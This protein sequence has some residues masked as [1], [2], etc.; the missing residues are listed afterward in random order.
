MMVRILAVVALAG[1]LHPGCH[2]EE[3]DG[4]API[5][6]SALEGRWHGTVRADDGR[7]AG[8]TLDVVDEVDATRGSLVAEG[9][10]CFQSGVIDGQVFGN[11]WT[12]A[13]TSGGSAIHFALG[14]SDG[15]MSGSYVIESDDP[16]CDARRGIVELQ[17]EGGAAG[18]HRTEQAHSH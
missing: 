13:A 8:L 4:A 14:E 15:V 12:P 2:A 18:T 9:M 3:D 17:R 7:I 16:R 10:Q 6:R 11:E 5:E 1:W